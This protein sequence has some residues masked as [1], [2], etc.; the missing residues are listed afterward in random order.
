MTDKKELL[1]EKFPVF[2]LR[3]KTKKFEISQMLFIFFGPDEFIWVITE[4]L[5][6][7]YNNDMY[8]L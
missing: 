8:M 5:I 7:Y 4:L 2:L 6:S 3:V 1:P